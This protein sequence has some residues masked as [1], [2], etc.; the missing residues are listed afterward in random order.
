MKAKKDKDNDV[1]DSTNDETPSAAKALDGR[2]VAIMLGSAIWLTIKFILY[3]SALVS[4]TC[5]E[6]TNI[7]AAGMSAIG[8]P[9]QTG[10]SSVFGGGGGEGDKIQSLRV[11][12]PP[13]FCM[14]FFWYVSRP[15]FSL[16]HPRSTRKS[17]VSPI[18]TFIPLVLTGL[19]LTPPIL[20]THSS[21]ANAYPQRPTPYS[22]DPHIHPDP[23]PPHLDSPNSPLNNSPLVSPLDL[24]RPI[25]QRQDVPLCRGYEGIRSTI[26]I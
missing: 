2:K 9:T 10:S 21:A 1:F 4:M 19:I 18:L 20:F 23:S 26:R 7:S 3:A 25:G 17:L 16:S 24:L 12:E 8:K 11:W 13:S 5:P 22:P 6:G 14:A 15:K